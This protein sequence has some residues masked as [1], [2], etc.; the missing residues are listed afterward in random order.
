[1]RSTKR[2][3]SHRAFKQL[4]VEFAPEIVGNGRNGIVGPFEAIQGRFY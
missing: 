1:M 4:D 3:E 2:V